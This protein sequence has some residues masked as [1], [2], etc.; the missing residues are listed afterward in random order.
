MRPDQ[1]QDRRSLQMRCDF[2]INSIANKWAAW[3][4]LNNI[5]GHLG[6]AAVSKEFA[7]GLNGIDSTIE[8]ISAIGAPGMSQVAGTIGMLWGAGKLGLAGV[9]LLR[10]ASTGTHPQNETHDHEKPHWQRWAGSGVKSILLGA[11]TYLPLI[12]QALN[13]A[14]AATDGINFGIAQFATPS[15]DVRTQ[16]RKDDLAEDLNHAEAWIQAA[17]YFDYALFT[18]VQEEPA[19]R[20]NMRL[21]VLRQKL[22]RMGQTHLG[23]YPK[24]LAAEKHLTSLMIRRLLE[25]ARENKIKENKNEVSTYCKYWNH[26][27]NEAMHGSLKTDV[28]KQH[29]GGAEI[30]NEIEAIRAST[31]VHPDP[32]T[33]YP[34]DKE[35]LWPSSGAD[36]ASQVGS[37]KVSNRLLG[38]IGAIP[39]D[40]RTF[41]LTDILTVSTGTMFGKR[42][43]AELFGI[44]NFIEGRSLTNVDLITFA[45][46]ARKRIYSQYPELARANSEVESI[47]RSDDFKRADSDAKTRLLN[48]WLSAQKALY[49]DALLLVP[50]R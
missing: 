7:I 44:M 26:Y 9:G 22:L 24:L 3:T 4:D 15:P 36:L 31:Q 50:A 8:G 46:D 1:H 39:A 10:Q 18:Q 42:D 20:L 41:T 27:L 19:G 37:Q 23:I 25:L 34:W 32:M 16:H 30:F 49:G 35:P 47:L 45:D 48:T 2:P 33:S 14:A 5:Q 28:L 13:L 6:M 43:V 12:G 21:S 40:A 11:A 29:V 38:T 17:Q